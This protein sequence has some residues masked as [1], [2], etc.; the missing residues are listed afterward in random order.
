MF[1]I[2][3]NRGLRLSSTDVIKNFI[4]GHA[5]HFGEDTLNEVKRL[6]ADIIINLDKINTDDFLR[7]F[8]SSILRKKISESFLI[9]E[10]KN[11]YKKRVKSSQGISD[12]SI[13]NEYP[14]E[15]EDS[16]NSNEDENPQIKNRKIK[17]TTFLKKIKATSKIYSKI[18]NKSFDHQAINK[19]LFD[20]ERI[21]SFPSNIF[22]LDLFSRKLELKNYYRVLEQIKAFMIRRN[23]CEYRTGEL[24]SIFANLCNVIDEHIEKNVSDYLKYYLPTDEE[25]QNYFQ[26]HQF[27]GKNKAR[28]KYVL[29]Q[30]EYYLTGNKNEYVINSS[31]EVHLEHIMPQKIT[32]NKSKEIYGDWENYLNVGDDYKHKQ[33]VW[34]IGNL[35][36][37]SDELNLGASNNPFIRKKNFYKQSSLQLNKEIVQSYR[38]FKFKDQER[39]S[40]YFANLAVKIWK[41]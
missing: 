25:F 23:I 31:E 14:E 15:D 2:I 33:Y 32:T 41:L 20:L 24:D 13:E 22:L 34:R 7:Q 4:L 29:E 3:N 18:I 36:L 8:L 40:R 35:T 21:Q 5:S 12:F 16:Y 39:R 9:S 19:S 28:A 6:W 11:Y 17:I 27:K 38:Q 1:E 30:I 10:F 26:K 37:L